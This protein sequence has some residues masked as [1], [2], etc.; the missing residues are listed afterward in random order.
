MQHKR[1][2]KINLTLGNY[3]DYIKNSL[4]QKGYS[5]F[6]NS[7]MIH[8]YHHSKHFQKVLN[9]ANFILPDGVPALFALNFF[10][11]A[12]QE[13]IAGNDIIFSLIEEARIKKYRVFFVGS[14]MEVLDK[15]ALKLEQVN[16]A[17]QMYSPPFK[18]I[19]KFEFEKQSQIIN[20]FDPDIILVG[21]GCPKQEYWMFHMKERVTAPMYGVGGAF[22]LYAGI[23]SRAPLL[24]RRL[25][26]E[27]LYRLLLEPKRLF[28]RYLLTN[29]YFCW[30]FLKGIFRNGEKPN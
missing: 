2:F 23:D 6:L 27:W 4:E 21:L 8:E 10:H 30:L 12:K 26:L 28:L 24:M 14:T 9:Q 7:H 25:G 5:C 29:T 11:K 1:L 20:E 13:R 18:P 3:E 16:V 19:E 15:I 17:F 22:L